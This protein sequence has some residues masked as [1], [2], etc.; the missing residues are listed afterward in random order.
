MK[1]ISSAFTIW[2]APKPISFSSEPTN[3]AEVQKRQKKN[4]NTKKASGFDKI[5][6]KLVKLSAEIVSTPH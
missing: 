6:P 3:P 1:Q 5:L 4:I 2:N